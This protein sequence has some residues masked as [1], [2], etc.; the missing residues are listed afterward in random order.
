MISLAERYYL[1]I[2]DRFELFYRGVIKAYNPYSKYVKATCKK[3]YT[4]PRYFTYTPKEGDE[5]EYTLTISI[6]DD[7]GHVLESKDTILVVNKPVAPK[8]KVNILCVGD[9]LTYNGVWAYEGY[10]R[11]TQEGEEPNC[12]G[13]KDTLNLFGKCKKEVGEYKIGYEGYGGWQWKTFCTDMANSPT[14]SL[15]VTCNHN[16]TD[17][18]Q[19]SVWECEGLEWILESIEENKLKFKR[20]NGNNA[21]SPKL[22]PVFK[23]VKNAANTEDIVCLKQEFNEG[24]PFWNKETNNIDFKNYVLE[25]GF[26]N[27]DYVFILLTWNGQANPY[28]TD[29]SIH[30]EYASKFIKQIHSDFP[31]AK[32][33]CMGIQLVCPIGGI[34]ACYGADGFYHDWYGEV[35]T[36]FNYNEWLEQLLNSNEFKDYCL[37]SDM[38]AQFDSEYNMPYKMMKVNNRSNQMERI[39]ING[40]HP[41]MDGYLQIGD[42]F[43][44][45]LV[46]VL[47][48]FEKEE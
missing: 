21:V 23:H 13:F 43:Y 34:T 1:V 27:P 16:K 20:G 37:Y 28:N 14:S 18:D 9:S 44:R 42:V 46:H 31:K 19:H 38:K 41:S 26:P 32:V 3:G 7:E 40:I 10:R 12:L 2:N 48:K 30:K 47:N 29:F 4:Y 6:Y 36:A 39:G 22:S 25:N 35:I 8:R 11:Y 45:T 24:N 17:E 15:W 5:G 33:I